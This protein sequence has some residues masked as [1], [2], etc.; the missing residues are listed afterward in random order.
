MTATV[1]LIDW[2]IVIQIGWL[3]VL[4][5]LVFILDKI[6]DAR[7]ILGFT[8]QTFWNQNLFAFLLALVLCFIGLLIIGPDIQLVDGKT[9]IL[10]A[11]G[12]GYG[13]GA[14]MRSVLKKVNTPKETEENETTETK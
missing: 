9:K 3:I 7:K 6:V 5:L 1:P 12:L 4:G 13:G 8:W 2:A 11:V 14:G 10:I